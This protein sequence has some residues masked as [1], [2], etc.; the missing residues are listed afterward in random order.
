MYTE[1]LNCV[2]YDY[3][4]QVDPKMAKK[5]KK[6]A[7][8]PEQL[9]PGSPGIAEIVKHF[10]ETATKK[11]KRKLKLVDAEENLLAAPV[12][13]ESVEA[14]TGKKSK[15]TKKDLAPAATEKV[16]ESVNEVVSGKKAKK[17]KKA[18]K[19]QN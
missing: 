1:L 13:E 16:E 4:T 19:N 14:V 8:V 17:A 3:L 10:N 9:P 15:R 18:K 7:N 5:F 6:E 2:V 11:I 12:K